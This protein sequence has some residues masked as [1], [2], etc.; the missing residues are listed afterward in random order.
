MV[1]PT[2]NHNDIAVEFVFHEQ[3]PRPIIN[4]ETDANYQA[5]QTL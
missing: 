5:T 1:S 4:N 2:E 3:S